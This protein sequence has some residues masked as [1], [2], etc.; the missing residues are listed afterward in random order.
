M[1]IDGKLI[2]KNNRIQIR[3]T[4]IDDIHNGKEIFEKVGKDHAQLHTVEYRRM[5]ENENTLYESLV[6]T[7][8]MCDSEICTIKER[9]WCRC[10]TIKLQDYIRTERISPMMH[11]VSLTRSKKAALL[12]IKIWKCVPK[13][14]KVRPK[15]SRDKGITMTIKRKNI[16]QN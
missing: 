5:K 9:I 6:D 12:S 2:L 3:V 16:K 8:V 4:P 1:D 15:K 7:T 13:R 14:W 10:C 11:I